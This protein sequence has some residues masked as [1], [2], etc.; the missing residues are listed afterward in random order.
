MLTRLLV[1]TGC[2]Q[3]KGQLITMFESTSPQSTQVF[4]VPDGFLVAAGSHVDFPP[5]QERLV[6]IRFGGQD[7]VQLR[8]S[9]LRASQDDQCFGSPHTRPV[10]VGMYLQTS[11]KLDECVF[12]AL[13]FEQHRPQP[14][15]GVG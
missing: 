13:L 14:C 3:R 11:T 8:Q 12:R 2:P 6:V 4:Q 5:L 10:Q 7:E 1:A 9:F 15:Q